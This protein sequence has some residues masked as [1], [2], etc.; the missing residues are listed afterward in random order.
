MLATGF[1]TL[2]RG[3]RMAPDHVWAIVVA[4]GILEHR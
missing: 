3:K 1:L 2:A 4:V